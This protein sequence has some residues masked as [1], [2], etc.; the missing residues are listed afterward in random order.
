[1]NKK[2]HSFLSTQ[3]ITATIS[4]TLV[5]VLLGIIVLFVIM[6]IFTTVLKGIED[7]GRGSTGFIVTLASFLV[8][9]FIF[10]SFVV[11]TM[12]VIIPKMN[13]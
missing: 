9:L 4:T 6:G 12:R 10:G 5:L 7:S 8:I 3:F 13:A 2:R 11:V 1:M